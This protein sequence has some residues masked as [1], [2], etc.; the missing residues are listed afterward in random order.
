MLNTLEQE[1]IGVVVASKHPLII[2]GVKT[3][4]QGEPDMYF[5][6]GATSLDSYIAAR[7]HSPS[8]LSVVDTNLIVDGSVLDTLRRLREVSRDRMEVV[9]LEE[10]PDLTLTRDFIHAGAMGFVPKNGPTG[11]I[12][13]AIRSVRRGEMW[14][15]PQQARRLLHLVVVGKTDE[16]PLDNLSAR[17]RE[18]FD[19]LGMGKTVKEIGEILH[20][21]VCTVHSHLVNIK[22]KFGSADM[23]KLERTAFI[24]AM[25]HKDP[26]GL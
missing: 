1:Q 20:I 23:R 11:Q 25:Q 4:I 6:A 16:R 2:A 21:A 22:H 26:E 3:E 9:I 8:C 14:M 18:I 19:L 10:V 7:E 17:E 24:Y 5:E 15:D 13:E 12:R